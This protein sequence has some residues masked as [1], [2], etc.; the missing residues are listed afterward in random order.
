M[1]KRAIVAGTGFEGRDKIIKAHCK[2]G[3]GIKLKRE[4]HNKYDPNAI[5]VYMEAPVL[6]GLLGQR[7]KQIGYV[8]SNSAESLATK[9]DSG[10]KLTAVVASFYA[11]P[12]REH[13]RVS[14]EI[15]GTLPPEK[16]KINIK[17]EAETLG[18]TKQGN[19]WEYQGT[20]YA[21]LDVAIKYAKAEK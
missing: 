16:T 6:F 9:M 21:S 2:E 5:A 4:P 13:P 1:R 14:I 8:K 17:L 15:V 11:P 3:A 19:H 7:F 10:M 18:I 12:D 20:K